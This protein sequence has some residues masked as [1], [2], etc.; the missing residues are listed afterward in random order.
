MVTTAWLSAR[1]ILAHQGPGHQL[2]RKEV[3]A[4]DA[5]LGCHALSLLPLIESLRRPGCIELTMQ[6]SNITPIWTW[7]VVLLSSTGRVPLAGPFSITSTA[8]FIYE[9]SQH[10]LVHARFLARCEK[11]T[12]HG[13]R[14]PVLGAHRLCPAKACIPAIPFESFQNLPW[15]S[16]LGVFA[17]KY[18]SAGPMVAQL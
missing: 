9:T 13:T 12:C 7:I 17:F 5:C 10:P 4:M 8:F 1:C 11:A 15:Q 2:L 3:S 18:S 14:Q 6:E 16:G